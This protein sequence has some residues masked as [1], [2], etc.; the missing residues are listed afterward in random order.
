MGRREG[1]VGK[2]VGKD[3]TRLKEDKRV[4]VLG[5]RGVRLED[6]EYGHTTRFY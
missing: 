5:V 4:Q 2:Q 3:G 6:I 1:E